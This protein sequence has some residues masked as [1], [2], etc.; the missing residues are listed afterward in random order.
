M[1]KG[2]ERMTLNLTLAARWMIVQTSD[3]RLTIGPGT[4]PEETAQKQV[5]LKYRNW[6]GLLCYTGIARCSATIRRSG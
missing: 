4:P 1:E 6:T 3:F 2:Q 5:V